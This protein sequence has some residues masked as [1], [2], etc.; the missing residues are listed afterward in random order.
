MPEGAKDCGHHKW[1]QC[2]TPGCEEIAGRGRR[3]CGKC[4]KLKDRKGYDYD[5]I[6][7]KRASKERDVGMDF[8]PWTPRPKAPPIM[9]DAEQRRIDKAVQ[10][11]L[12]AK[13]GYGSSPV[14]VYTAEEI[15]AIAPQV[16]PPHLIKKHCQREQDLIPFRAGMVKW[17]SAG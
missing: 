13:C 10:D 1:N 14:R 7:G 2:S 12:H 5:M 4:R 3:I 9:T 6:V 15:K 17:Q 8:T 11:R 16:T